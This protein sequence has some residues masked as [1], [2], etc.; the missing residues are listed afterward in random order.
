MEVSGLG[1]HDSHLDV[2]VNGHTDESLGD[3]KVVAKFLVSVL[4]DSASS[5]ILRVEHCV[6]FL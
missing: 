5:L 6:I 3:Q 2:E 4:P 1:D